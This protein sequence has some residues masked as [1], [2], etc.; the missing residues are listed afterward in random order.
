MVAH[1]DAHRHVRFVVNPR[2]DEFEFLRQARVGFWCQ[3][4]MHTVRRIIL[5]RRHHFHRELLVHL[6]FW[7]ANRQWE[8]ALPKLEEIDLFARADDLLGDLTV[9]AIISLDELAVDQFVIE[10]FVDLLAVIFL[11]R[12]KA[13]SDA[14]PLPS[15]RSW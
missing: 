11:K 9:R 3:L 13:D 4:D 2:V 12:V 1:H 7:L 15:P 8:G 6:F 14:R 10:L 5:V